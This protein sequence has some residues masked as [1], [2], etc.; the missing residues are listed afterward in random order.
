M[1]TTKFCEDLSNFLKLVSTKI[2]FDEND[3]VENT[4]KGI[5]DSI[6]SPSPSVKIH[7]MGGKVC[8]R[9]K[10]K[11]MLGIVNKLLKKKVC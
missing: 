9:C 11:I 6:P 4:L 2:R 3:K 5:L 10:G 7:I 1:L 8:L